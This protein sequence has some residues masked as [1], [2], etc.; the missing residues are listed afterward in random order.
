MQ[1]KLTTKD[2]CMIAL[3]TALISIMAQISI[4][5]PLGVPMTMQTFAITMAAIMLGAQKGCI[6]SS[7]YVLLGIIGIPVFANLKGGIHI[8]LSPTGGFILSFP[9][10]AWLIGLGTEYKNKI[11]GS[12]MI[13]L[14]LGTTANYIIGTFIF[15]LITNSTLKTGIL[16]CVLPFI[17]TAILKAAL[18]SFLAL[19]SRRLILK[20]T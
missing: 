14:V 10:M 4:P 18:A 11:K 13:G 7:I 6:A 3:W 2:L 8:L 17:P 19:K 15:C 9:L 16:G 5:M 20:L 1:K 12:F